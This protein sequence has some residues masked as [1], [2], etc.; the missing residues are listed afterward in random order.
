[1]TR[2]AVSESEDSASEAEHGAQ[3]LSLGWNG[4]SISEITALFRA[5]QSHANR[6]DSEKAETMFLKAL[7]GYGVLLGPTHEDA[8]KVAIAVANF[9]TEQGRFNDAD[10]VVEELCQHYIKKFGF[11]DR[12]TRQ[13]ILQVVELLNGCDR[14]IDAAAFLGRSKEL[15]EADAEEVFRRPNKRSKSRRQGSISRRHAATPSAEIL[16]AEEITA[17]SDPDQIEYGIQ[18]ARTHVAVK[19]GAVEAYLKAIIEHCQGHGEALEIQNLRARCELSKFYSKIAQVHSHNSAFSSA[20]GTAEAIIRRERWEKERFKSFETMEA[21]LELVASVL[22]AGFD[23]QA[24]NTFT[25]IIQKA[26]ND[27]GWD[28]ERTIWAKISIGIVFQRYRNWESAKPWFEFAHAA[29]FV[30]NGEEDGITRSLQTAM[31]KRHFSYVSDEGRPFKTIF[32]VS[33]LMV[34]PNRLHLD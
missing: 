2:R 12:R 23:F 18:V 27:F 8:T 21:L 7:K 28:D 6:A 17:G 14:Q 19:D 3:A 22:K 10:K 1:M 24:A 33:G 20:I 26:D 11:K 15:A 31:E 34:R 13:V 32:G 25:Q 5:A 29:S 30:A 9:Y 16:A 4:N